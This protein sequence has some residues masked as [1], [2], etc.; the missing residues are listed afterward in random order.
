MTALQ[1]T[2]G[3]K[4]VS[5]PGR[6]AVLGSASRAGQLHP[7]VHWWLC[8]CPTSFSENLRSAVQRATGACNLHQLWRGAYPAYMSFCW[9]A[10]TEN[11]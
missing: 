2:G 10:N 6:E 5:L 4:R 8:T 7:R 9:M 1:Y 3:P 11:M